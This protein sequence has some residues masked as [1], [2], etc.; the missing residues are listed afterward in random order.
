MRAGRLCLV[1]L[2]AIAAAETVTA[3]VGPPSGIV[4]YFAILFVLLLGSA[5]VG[6]HLSH[7]LFLAVGL[8]PLIR[9]LSL[10]MPLAEFSQVYWYLIISVPMLVGIFGVIT[11]LNLQPGEVG[12]TVGAIR[13]QGVVAL[14]GILFGLVEYFI[15]RPEP[16]ILALRWQEIIVPVLVLLV[17]T[18]L[19]EEL[20]FR[21][22]MQRAS[23]EVLGPWGWVFVAA[24]FTL[25]QIGHLSALHCLFVL[26]VALFFG[27]M[28]K[29]TGSILGVSLS[30]GLLNVG[31]Y[32]IFPFVF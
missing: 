10:S 21:G 20:A 29:R 15:L 17:A 4:F 18:G 32:L 9:I 23:G 3:L 30:H 12:L 25:V 27:W 14:T 28:V 5:V 16:L 8:V 31:L 24:L 2:A 7:R 22:V 19:V 6:K 26:P 13:L 11:A 1:C